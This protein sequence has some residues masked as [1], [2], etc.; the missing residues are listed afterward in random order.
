MTSR[1]RSAGMLSVVALALLVEGCVAVGVGV[2]VVAGGTSTVLYR[3]GRLT[4]PV[5][6]T[7]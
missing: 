7:S 5:A 4:A 3:R 2:A 6:A 1:V